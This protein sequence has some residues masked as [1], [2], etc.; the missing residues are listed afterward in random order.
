MTLLLF[1]TRTGEPLA[2]MPDE[3]IQSQRVACTNAIAARHIASDDADTLGLIGAGW[4]ASAQA[5]A[6]SNVRNL[7][8]IRA[9]VQPA[10]RERL[11]KE[12][13]AQLNVLVRPV[14]S[15]QAAAKDADI[16]GIRN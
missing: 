13:G 9:T 12:L 1:S 2:I 16:V 15:A 6:M 7:R 14:D 3:V 8:E 4:Q 10:N 11:A 5:L